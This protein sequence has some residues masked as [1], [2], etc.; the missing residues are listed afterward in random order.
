VTGEVFG[1]LRCDCGGQLQEAMRKIS[2]EGAGAIV[3]LAQEG[4][5]IGLLN[6]VR[7][8]GLQDTQGLDTVD[9]NLA[10]GFAADLRDFGIGAQI[11]A[12]LGL[13]SIRLLTNNPRK[14][15]GLDGYGLQVSGQVPIEVPRHPESERYMLSKALRMGHQLECVG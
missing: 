3:Y 2:R 15:I 13:S 5:G 11:L 12:D 14:I 8:Y 6:K 9:A 4:R 1:S 7:A 10:L